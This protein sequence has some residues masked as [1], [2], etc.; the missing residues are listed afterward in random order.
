MLVKLKELGELFI[1]FKQF[2]PVCFCKRRDKAGRRMPVDHGQAGARQPSH[3]A[4][5]HHQKNQQANTQ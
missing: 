4:N 1:T 2:L 3:A 5:H